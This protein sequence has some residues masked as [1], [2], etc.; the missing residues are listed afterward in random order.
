MKPNLTAQVSIDFR[1]PKARVWK[2]LT[3][4]TDIKLYFFGT[5]LV[6]EWIV[7]GPIRFVGEWEGKSYEDK[8][9]VLKF[10]PQKMLQYDY[11]SSLSGKEDKQ[12]NYQMITYRVTEKDGITNVQIFR[13]SETEEAREHS[14][15]SWKMVLEDMRNLVEK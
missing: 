2:A 7:G 5:N 12:E 1:A 11:W 8:G 4:P 10:D 3:D 15:Q 9:T 13:D 14:E 6:T